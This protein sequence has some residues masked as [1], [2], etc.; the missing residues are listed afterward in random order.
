MDEPTLIDTFGDEWLAHGDPALVFEDGGNGEAW[1][2]VI[3]DPDRLVDFE[4]AVSHCVAAYLDSPANAKQTERLLAA[5]SSRPD[6]S[7]EQF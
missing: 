5:L 2:M 7:E 4:D 6:N 1:V 3:S